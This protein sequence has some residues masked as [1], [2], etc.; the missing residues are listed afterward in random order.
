MST[1]PDGMSAVETSLVDYPHSFQDFGAYMS[2]PG[3]EHY[4]GNYD[5]VFDSPASTFYVASNHDSRS[6][7]TVSNLEQGGSYHSSDHSSQLLQ[8]QQSSGNLKIF[9][10][11]R[12]GTNRDLVHDITTTR[13][14]GISSE[15]VSNWLQQPRLGQQSHTPT[16]PNDS[17]LHHSLPNM[18]S[19]EQYAAQTRMNSTSTAM[20]SWKSFDHEKDPVQV[21]DGQNWRTSWNSMQP[22]SRNV[23]TVIPASPDSSVVMGPGSFSQGFHPMQGHSQPQPQEEMKTFS[24]SHSDNSLSVAS[25]EGGG[26]EHRRT[27]SIS[28]PISSNLDM[29]PAMQQHQHHNEAQ[30]LKQSEGDIAASMALMDYPHQSCSNPSGSIRG[31]REIS[32]PQQIPMKQQQTQQLCTELVH[33][34]HTGSWDGS[35]TA[36]S[37]IVS[38]SPV[39]RR[40]TNGYHNSPLI[41]DLASSPTTAGTASLSVQQ[42]QHQEQHNQLVSQN[43]N[44]SNQ[45][46]RGLLLVN[47]LVGCADA[48]AN[49]NQGQAMSLLNELSQR[50]NQHGDSIERVASYF[51]YGLLAHIANNGSGSSINRSVQIKEPTVAD[52]L[53]A[54]QVFSNVCPFVR[55]GE[56]A[57]IQTFLEAFEREED[58]HWVDLGMV[59]GSLW[60]PCNLLQALAA[61]KGGPPKMIHFTGV[62]VNVSTNDDQTGRQLKEFADTLNLNFIF[63][64]VP[65][66]RLE[67]LKPWMLTNRVGQ[68]VAVNC[69]AKMHTLLYD[70]HGNCL[71]HVLAIIHS[72]SPKVFCFLEQEAT[73]NAPTFL[74]RFLEA[75][76]FYSAIF[77]SLEASLTRGSQE[78]AKI[79]QLLLGQAIINIVA[80]EGKD[81]VERHERLQ[82]WRC[83]MAKSGYQQKP[84]SEAAIAQVKGLPSISYGTGFTVIEDRGSLVLNW[85][86]RPLFT[87]SAW[88]S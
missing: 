48:V 72:L 58:V 88:C 85:Q 27:L 86:D 4:S 71:H 11:P 22:P 28:S 83:R 24:T 15:D 82:Q 65:I 20:S 59:P 57:A 56:V 37:A 76:H 3:I 84:L 79:E 12:T 13:G 33:P 52:T 51:T 54:L 23:Q 17:E 64:P 80:R 21:R 70:E 31:S 74:A 6:S 66:E 45:Q 36:E 49:N 73:H 69:S 25:T 67:K 35:I 78:R 2:E 44:H 60:L 7:S 61:R 14:M 46:D 53:D 41:S 50:V 47:L 40:G 26:G 43:E 16:N 87:C 68:A 38:S 34:G 63:Q 39:S 75:L 55:F 8:Q 77:D 5:P 81:R 29:T 9:R 30:H 42:Q 19:F 32:S 62:Q 10:G 1:H 18:N